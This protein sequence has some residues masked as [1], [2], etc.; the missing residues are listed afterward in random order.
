MQAIREGEKPEIQGIQERKV[1]TLDE[2]A[3]G[4]AFLE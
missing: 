2:G 1:I 3:V 4:L